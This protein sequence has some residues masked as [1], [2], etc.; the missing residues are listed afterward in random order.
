MIERGILR[1]DHLVLPLD[2]LDTKRRE[3]S[4]SLTSKTD[5]DQQFIC[6]DDVDQFFAGK[7][8]R[9][10]LAELFVAPVL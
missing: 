4:V 10:L 9:E 2:I 6:T 5:D 7:A 1:P 8:L 3:A